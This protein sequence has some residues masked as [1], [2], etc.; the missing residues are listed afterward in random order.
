[1]NVVSTETKISHNELKEHRGQS[2][3]T[4][5]FA[6]KLGNILERDDDTKVPQ[7]VQIAITPFLP[8]HVPALLLSS[9]YQPP[10]G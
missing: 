6:A 2:I 5:S 4:G 8:H 3:K 9:K 7:P 10:S 1:M